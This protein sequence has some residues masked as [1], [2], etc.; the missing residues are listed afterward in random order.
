[1]HKAYF[2]VAIK[3]ESKVI[4]TV[5]LFIAFRNDVKKFKMRRENFNKN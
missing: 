1:M 4:V 5:E 2:K 3:R